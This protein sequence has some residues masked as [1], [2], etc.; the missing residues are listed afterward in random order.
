MV[1]IDINYIE[2]H[3][4]KGMKW[5]V[6]KET[7]TQKTS[8]GESITFHMRPQGLIATLL[9]KMSKRVRDN[10]DFYADFDMKNEKGKKIGNLACCKETKDSLNIVWLST[11]AGYEGKGYGT[12]A[13][14]AAIAFAKD[15][16]MKTVTL[17][18]P[19]ISPN[20]RHIYEK[21]G[22]KSKGLVTDEDDIWGG[23]TAMQLDLK[24]AVSTRVFPTLFTAEESIIMMNHII[25]EL[26]NL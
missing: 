4:V 23:L 6:R 13:T 14:K 22:F 5:G 1:V 25:K 7:Y 21:L 11:N 24:H 19:G 3:G 12:V 26:N 16:N 20:A 2:H 10:L 9:S 18:V 17:E 8:R 15:L